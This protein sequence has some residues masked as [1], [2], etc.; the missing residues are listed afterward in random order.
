M[1]YPQITNFTLARSLGYCGISSVV[2]FLGIPFPLVW[3]QVDCENTLL[4]HAKKN[5]NPKQKNPNN[6]KQI[7]GNK[8]SPRH[9]TGAGSY[10][11]LSFLPYVARLTFLSLSVIL[12]SSLCSISHA[13]HFEYG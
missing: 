10:A 11:F 12:V 5:Q 13:L 8:Q 2:H 9:P 4:P 3:W 6:K 1:C 7:A